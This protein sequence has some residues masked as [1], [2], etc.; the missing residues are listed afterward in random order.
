MRVALVCPYDPAVPGGVQNHVLGLAAALR[1]AG[2]RAQVLAP[3]LGA[4]RGTPVRWNGSIARIAWGPHVAVA[5]RRWLDAQD[6]DLVHVHEPTAPSVGWH[7]LRHAHR[8]WPTVA[9][10]HQAGTPAPLLALARRGLG[11]ALR[12]LGAAI[13]V[14]EVARAA[15]GPLRLPAPVVIPNGVAVDDWAAAGH[16]PPEPAV[17]FIGRR[18]DPRKGF[19][20][21]AAAARRLAPTHPHVA[22]WAL[23]P[24][25]PVGAPLTLPDGPGPLPT[26]TLRERV[27]RAAI[28]V[29]PN[30]GHESFGMVLVE[31]LAAGARVV[32]SDLAAFRAVLD[33]G[34]WGDLVPVGDPAAL[35]AAVAAL[36]DQPDDPAS[37]RARIAHARTYSW[38]PVL[39]QI[40]AQYHRARARHEQGGMT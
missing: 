5:V 21:F 34:R 16:W 31:A 12:D 10:F 22:W 1:A 26:R 38:H 6:P 17:A 40:L 8:R 24:G 23:G 36:L 28:V 33:Q 20:T 9:T 32:A 14:S 19:A 37:R 4:P 25:G 27:G 39:A 2:H 30:T 29:A 13:C 7:A 15:A 18:G 3:G 35:A 11:G